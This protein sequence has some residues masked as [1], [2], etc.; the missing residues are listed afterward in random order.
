MANERRPKEIN[1][2][3][4]EEKTKNERTNGSVII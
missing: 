1:R 3:Q 4:F 2:N